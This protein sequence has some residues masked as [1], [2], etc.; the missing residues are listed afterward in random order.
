MRYAMKSNAKRIA[1]LALLFTSSAC[2]HNETPPPRS[3][4]D[5]CLNDKALTVSTAPAAGVDDPGNRYDTDDTSLQVFT[6]NA[7]YHSLCPAEDPAR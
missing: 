3:V 7:V 1:A 4:S 6:H 5:F 2:A